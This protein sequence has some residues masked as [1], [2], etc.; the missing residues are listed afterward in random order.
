MR[1]LRILQRNYRQRYGEID[2]IAWDGATLAFIEI[3]SRQERDP[4]EALASV[5]PA[6]QRRIIHTA[7]RFLS[8]HPQLAAL[9]Q[10]FDILAIAQ[11]RDA[12]LAFL[13]QKAAFSS[14]DQGW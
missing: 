4:N 5:T 13:W 12:S 8:Q 10:R 14:Q 2:I 6:K 7:Q 1:G 9:S 11:Q 3:R